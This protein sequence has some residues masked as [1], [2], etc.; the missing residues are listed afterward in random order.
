MN[1]E[2]AFRTALAEQDDPTTRAIFADYLD[3]SGRHE[4]ALMQRIMSSSVREVGLKE[5]IDDYDWGEVFGEGTGGN[6]DKTTDACPPGAAID[7]TPPTR[8]DVVEVV[9][10]VNGVPDE[11][12]WVGVFLLRDGRWLLADAECDY[13]GWD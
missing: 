8:A 12:N 10:A 13:T 2:Q 3:D 6:C 7:L 9:A 11:Q 4:E 5:L 1:D